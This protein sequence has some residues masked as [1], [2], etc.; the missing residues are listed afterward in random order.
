[1]QPIALDA[2]GDRSRVGS[3]AFDPN[4]G[5]DRSRFSSM[6][7]PQPPD[8]TQL[9][10][11]DRAQ[12]MDTSPL[13]DGWTSHHGPTGHIFW[14]HRMS[15]TST[16]VRPVIPQSPNAPALHPHQTFFPSDPNAASAAAAGSAA[17]AQPL[18]PEQAQYHAQ[19]SAQQHTLL[20]LQAQAAVEHELLKQQQA[21]VQASFGMG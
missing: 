7:S 20:Q 17:G 19:Q 13:P 16:Y 5:A 4:A 11:V 10:M 14:H 18:T 6:A 1:M 9:I 15:N 2:G 8:V 21:G 12:Q 3:V